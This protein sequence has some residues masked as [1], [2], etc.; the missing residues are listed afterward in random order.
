MGP[1]G[2]C[3]TFYRGG[4]EIGTPGIPSKSQGTKIFGSNFFSYHKNQIIFYDIFHSMVKNQSF[5][6]KASKIVRFL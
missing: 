5:V 4:P 2:H 1:K 6:A 3:K